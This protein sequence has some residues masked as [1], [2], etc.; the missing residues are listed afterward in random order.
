MSNPN[1]RVLAFQKGSYIIMEGTKADSFYILRQGSIEIIRSSVSIGEEKKK[2]LKPG[3]FFGVIAAM[4]KYPHLE[5]AVALSNVSVIQISYN[6]FSFLLKNNYPVAIKIIKYFSTK[7]RIFDEHITNLNQDEG[8]ITVINN[9]PADMIKIGELYARAGENDKAEQIY[10]KFFLAY[11]NHSLTNKV[12]EMLSDLEIDE[13][14]SVDLKQLAS[15]KNFKTGSLIFCEY[16]PGAQ[17]YIIRQ[18]KVKITKFIQDRE[19]VLSIL[20]VGDVFGEMALLE[21]KPRSA[22][23]FAVEDAELL[24][25]NKANFKDIVMNQTQLATRIIFL[26]SERIWKAYKQLFN[27]QINDPEGKVIDI[28]FTLVESSKTESKTIYKFGLLSEDILKMSSFKSGTTGYFVDEIISRYKNFLTKEEDGTITCTK[29]DELSR[30]AL[31][32]R[33]KFSKKS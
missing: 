27:L 32:Y 30:L 8:N 14:N 28:L 9:P 21:D 24:S 11:P 19:I 3:D 29:I 18:G 1:F 13:E 23:A 12:K 2:T 22:S 20:K 25:V 16:E 5:S 6:N 15:Q 31:Y 33:K 10:K 4:G 7:L 17:L 26:L